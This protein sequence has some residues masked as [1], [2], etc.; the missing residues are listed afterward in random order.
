MQKLILSRLD[1]VVSQ[2]VKCQITD[3][4]SQVPT[5]VNIKRV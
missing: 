4:T 5:E 3:S 2:P 1:N